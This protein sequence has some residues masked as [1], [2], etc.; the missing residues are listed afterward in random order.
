[1]YNQHLS[2]FPYPI[3]SNLNLEG[4]NGHS[5]EE[6]TTDT[7][8]FIGPF[9]PRFKFRNHFSSPQNQIPHQKLKNSFQINFPFFSRI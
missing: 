5:L 2:T 9:C 1:M 7:N 8:H 3:R 4:A 6:I